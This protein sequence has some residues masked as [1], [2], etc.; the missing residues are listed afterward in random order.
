MAKE[1]VLDLVQYV[2]AQV[3]T[4]IVQLMAGRTYPSHIM[5]GELKPFPAEFAASRAP[6][7]GFKGVIC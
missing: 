6:F 2:F 4:E 3:V 7:Q 5:R 1:N